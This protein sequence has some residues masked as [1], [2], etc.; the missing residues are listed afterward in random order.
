MSLRRSP[1]EPARAGDAS[2]TTAAVIGA[3]L[4][5]AFRALGRGRAGPHAGRAAYPP[6][7]VR[8]VRRTRRARTPMSSMFTCATDPET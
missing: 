4:T 7:P 2:R 6:A 1:V 5:A 3:L 8:P